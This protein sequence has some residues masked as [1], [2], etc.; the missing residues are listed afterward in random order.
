MK[1]AAVVL[2]LAL[3]PLQT[4][5]SQDVGQGAVS[6]LVLDR[7]TRSALPDVQVTVVGTR[8]AVT[9]GR[10]GKF[11]IPNLPAGDVIVRLRLIG[12]AS[13]QQVVSIAAGGTAMLE[14]QLQPQAVD[15]EAQVVVGYG[16]QRREDL[17][18][19]V[20]SV[21]ADEFVEG[22]ARDAASLI[23]GKVPGLAVTTPSGDPRR[24]T[25]ISL[26]G[27][28][29][30]IGSRD[31]LVLVDGIPGDLETVAPQDIES[32]DV[33]KDGSAAAV[34]G[35]RASNGVIL[36]TT[37]KNKGREPTI[38]YETYASQQR[39][40]K[41]P[42]FLTAT[43]Y[44]RL[45]SQGYGF[46]DLGYSTDWQSLV[47]REPLSENHNLT[48]MGGAGQTN[49]TAALNYENGQ[50]I[51]LRSDN[52]ALS[53]RVNV[54]HAMYDGRLEADL[55]FETRLQHYFRGPDYNYAW[56]QALIRNPTDR[57]QDDS[58][59]WQERGTYFYVNPVGWIDENNGAYD[60]RDLRLHGTLTARPLANLRLSMLAGTE[61]GSATSGSATTFRHVNTTQSGQNGTAE[62]SA[63]EDVNHI[64]EFTG[65]YTNAIGGA[66]FTL[67]GGY[68]YQ[69]FAND[70][71]SVSTYDFPTDLFGYNQLQSGSA[72][73]RGEA[74][75]SSGSSSYKVIGFFS[76]LNYDWNNRL[77]VMGSLR[78]EGNSRFGANHKWGM[79]PAISA[80]WRLS[81]A[82]FVKNAHFVDDLKLRV[83]YGVTGIAPSSSY[84]SLT[85]YGYGD[86]FLYDGSWVQG[87][88]PLRNP[89]PD[90]RWERKDEINLGLDFSLFGYRLAGAVDVYRRDTKDMLF[91][92]SVPVP[93]YLFGT[94]LANVGHMRNTGAE[95]QL[96]YNVVRSPAVRWTTSANWSTNANRLLSLSNDVYRT[97]D[98]FYAGYTGE[99]IQQSTHRIDV[100]GP[101]GNFYGYKSVD[102]DSAG[103]WI[104]L[105]RNGNRI[106]IANATEADRRVLGNG[107]PKQYLAWNNTVQW[108]RLDLSVSMRGAFSFQILNFQRLFYENP[109]I[110]QYNMLKSAFD[111]VY[112]KRPVNYDLAY[113]S[114]YIENGDYWKL[115]NVTLGYRLPPN[116]AAALKASDA[117]VYFSGRNLLTIT[118]YKGMDPEVSTRGI[119]GLSPGTDL[120]DQYPTTRMFTAGVSL[121][122]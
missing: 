104:V 41:R 30:I 79:F 87:L 16:T 67:L 72:L 68:S 33:L 64:L 11:L 105:D 7:V 43:D 108:K 21:T 62:R 35:S 96:T 45:I 28:T 2:V 73:G 121:T 70:G 34:Y 90:L 92:Y 116:V 58:G 8:I 40:Y 50:G 3:L 118:G 5:R 6:G 61:Q 27:V 114:Y 74:N 29:T 13:A 109:T 56:R 111:P 52:R 84:L 57:V 115:D 78:Y 85:S 113:V 95:V 93:P 51:F 42:D 44:R 88:S 119:D 69:D 60:G 100:G 48:I 14:M 82:S 36:I 112:G 4:A 19:A 17:T 102:I 86:R 117:R 20:T 18:G 97:S 46:Q 24:G 120:R 77:L 26:R 98:Y 75:M 99:P 91:N 63:S 12:Y 80:G 37:K 59:M 1:R 9:S 89:N 55:N 53:G 65:T 54:Q 47:L 32:V 101:I 23:S 22:P 107:L 49:Y 71:F 106:P 83:G 122:F 66:G 15:L 94:I 25:E 31:P 10:D 76:R 39:L 110:L 81:E 38:R 103:E